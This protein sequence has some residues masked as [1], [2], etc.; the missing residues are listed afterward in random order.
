MNELDSKQ[1][2]QTYTPAYTKD[3]DLMTPDERLKG[4]VEIMARGALRAAEKR[5][6]LKNSAETEEAA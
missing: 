3:A 1:Q 6:L 5:G 2:A 4:F